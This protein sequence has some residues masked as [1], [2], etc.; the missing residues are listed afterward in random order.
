[1]DIHYLRTRPGRDHVGDLE[2]QGDAVLLERRKDRV[3]MAPSILHRDR[4]TPSPPEIRSAY[5]GLQ[6]KDAEV[7][8]AWL[9]L[10]QDIVREI[11]YSTA[12]GGIAIDADMKDEAMAAGWRYTTAVK[13]DV[14]VVLADTVLAVELK[15]F[16]SLGALGQALG[17]AA[18]LDL[19]PLNDLPNV[20]TVIAND[21]SPEVRIV[22][23]HYSVNLQ[24]IRDLT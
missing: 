15:P 23:A 14:L 6:P 10:N 9:K 17:Y 3:A 20:P 2:K 1:M 21:T 8:S 16:A 7:W 13:P 19:D 24:I 4:L 12:L 18:L 22:A 11:Y 5:P